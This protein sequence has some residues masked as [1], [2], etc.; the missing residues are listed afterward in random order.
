MIHRHDRVPIGRRSRLA[1][2]VATAVLAALGGCAGPEGGQDADRPVMSR[3][4][5]NP[6][7]ATLFVDGGFV[8]VTPT[9]FHLPAKPSV[10]VRI[11]YPGYF[12][13]DTRLDRQLGLPPDAPAGTGWDP[14]YYFPLV[15]K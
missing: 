13:I 5:T 11:E 9:A 4:D 6:Q 14:Q 7:G 8:G 3:F 10:E 15:R 2:L 1:S 12:P